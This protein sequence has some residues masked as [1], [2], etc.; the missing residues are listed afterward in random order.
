MQVNNVSMAVQDLLTPPFLS[1]NKVVIIKNPIF[2]TKTKPE[3]DHKLEL[4]LNYLDNLFLK[5]S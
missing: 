2:L 1:D 3:I 4:L 5:N